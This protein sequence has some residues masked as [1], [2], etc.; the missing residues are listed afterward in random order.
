MIII[1]SNVKYLSYAGIIPILI[2]VIGSFD[3]NLM[4]NSINTWLVEFGLLFSALILSFL[5]GCLFIFEIHLK[6]EI[7]F[8]GILISM[9]PSIWAVF[10][11]LLPMSCFFLA[12]GFLATLERERSLA[13]I[14]IF[15]NWWLKMR[16]RLT[17][18]IVL[19]LVIMGFNV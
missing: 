17:T 2:G 11:L 13:K 9:C 18:L 19:L 3:L 12:I 14:I 15:P 6:S 1:P 16:F 4:S 7:D 5:G 8:K 10:S